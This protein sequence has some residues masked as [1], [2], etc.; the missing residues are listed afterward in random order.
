VA[1]GASIQSAHDVLSN[2]DRE[3]LEFLENI[4]MDLPTVQHWVGIPAEVGR[5]RR[6][7]LAFYQIAVTY[8]AHDDASMSLPRQQYTP[9]SRVEMKAV[10]FR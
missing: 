4:L 1:A 10:G 7:N 6:S 3:R 9:S 2:V 8:S 5:C